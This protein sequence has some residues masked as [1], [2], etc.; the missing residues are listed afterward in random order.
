MTDSTV[1]I[2]RRVEPHAH[3][4]WLRLCAWEVA[5]TTPDSVAAIRKQ[6]EGHAGDTLVLETCQRIEVYSL[7]ACDCPAPL[8][9]EAL[10]ALQH[11]GEVAAGLHAAV[12]GEE[13]VLGQV[14]S[15]VA[16]APAS[17]RRLA[18][19]AVGCARHLRRHEG[20][21]GD[22]GQVLDKALALNGF[23]PGGRL[24]VFGSGHVARLVTR[25]AIQI[26]FAVTVAARTDPRATWGVDADWVTLEDALACDPFDVAVGCLGAAAGVLAPGRIPSARLLVDLGTPRNFA[27]VDGVPLVTIADVIAAETDASRAER[28][29][30]CDGLASLLDNRI[31]RGTRAHARALAELREE[32]ERVRRRELDRI[33][34]LHP[35]ISPETAGTIT[36]SL[37]N[38]LF[39]EPSRRLLALGDAELTDRFVELF[40]PGAEKA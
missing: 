26:G 7:E 11:L 36:R 30:L 20:L 27:P 25:R 24:I 37:V 22:T 6:V 13:Q 40:N 39:H 18:G 32:I 15:A 16:E 14:R 3:L 10:D 2:A 35:E 8:H 12:P 4:P 23:G 34:R 5:S 17:L 9:L 33:Q 21:T 19:I 38:R 29:R 31:S 28:D 1:T